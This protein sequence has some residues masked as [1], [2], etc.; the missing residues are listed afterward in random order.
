MKHSRASRLTVAKRQPNL[1]WTRANRFLALVALVGI[2]YSS[3][4]ELV[5]FSENIGTGDGTLS[6]ANNTF[7]NATPITFSGTADTRDTTPSSGY[8]GASGG[9]NVF[10][11][12]VDGRDFLISGIDTGVITN[13]HL[14]FGHFKSAI[15]ANNEL[16]VEVS[17]DGENWSELTYS[18]ATGSGTAN[19][20]RIEPEG[21]IPETDNLRIR[22]TQ[23]S[24]NSSFRIDDI[25]L[26]G[27]PPEG[28]PVISVEGTPGMLSTSEGTASDVTSVEISG[29][30]LSDDIT[31]TAPIG[32]EISTDE[33]FWDD[34][35]LLST[36]GGTLYIRLAA[37]TSAGSYSGNISFESTGA[38]TENVAVSGTVISINPKL[39][40]RPYTYTQNFNSFTNAASI[41]PGW[42]VESTG[43]ILAYNGDWGSGT[44][45]GLRGN[46]NVL[47]YQHTGSTGEF[48][49]TLAIEND[50]GTTIRELLVSYLGRVERVTQNRHPEWTVEV[51]GEEVPKLHYSTGSGIDE[52]LSHLVP[53]L[54][55]KNGE[56]FTII[57]ASDYGEGSGASRQIGIGDV[58][59]SAPNIR[60]PTV[61][62]LQ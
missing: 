57:W 51:A 3:I 50:T 56:I 19:W 1:F 53:N 15:D 5:I 32:F 27:T 13:L 4:A 29:T 55:I 33:I 22:F 17:D 36:S 20:K 35:V 49:V 43:G 62:I 24:T 2:P 54:N 48:I 11:T 18:R 41:P 6:I 52:E 34:I 21:V 40:E 16:I 45:G 46:D 37:A 10:F 60:K 14:S 42:S 9:R 59:V 58:S 39:S 28:F 23:T 61:I 31:A 26:R 38:Y 47:G 8:D 44:A 25:E 12:N 7:E 30:N